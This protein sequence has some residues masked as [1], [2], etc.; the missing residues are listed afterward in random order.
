MREFKLRLPRLDE[1]KGENRLSF[2]KSRGAVAF[3]SEYGICLGASYEKVYGNINSDRQYLGLYYTEKQDPN[4]SKV[5]VIAYD[6][7]DDYNRDGM[8]FD[9]ESDSRYGVRNSYCHG[10]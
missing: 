10:L 8:I 4:A 1:V 2:I 3:I 9:V 5:K 6:L 7:K